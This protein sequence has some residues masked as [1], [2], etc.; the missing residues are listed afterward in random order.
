MWKQN[1]PMSNLHRL[2][3]LSTYFLVIISS[4]TI[5]QQII[6]E[7]DFSD[8]N[9]TENAAWTDPS[10]RYII[11]TTNELQL[12]A[13]AESDTAVIFT[14]STAAFGEWEFLVRYD[15]NPS[16]TSFARIYL[17]ADTSRM[18][19]AV[20]GYYVR[21]GHTDDEVSLYRQDGT[22]DVKII[23][24][25][26]DLID[27]GSVNVRI[28]VTRSTDGS[29]ELLAD[30]AGGQ[31]YT[32]Q[33]TTQD[34]THTISRFFGIF[35][36]YIGSRSTLYF[37]DDVTVI[38]QTPPLVVESVLPIDNNNIEVLFNIPLN[39]NTVEVSD[40]LVNNGIGIP[41]QISIN[42]ERMVS[43]Q[44]E[45]AIPGGSY[46]LA[47]KSQDIEDSAGNSLSQDTIIPFTL[48]D[49]FEPGDIVINEFMYDPPSGLPEYIELIN[50]SSK[51]LN[52]QNWKLEDENIGNDIITTDSLVMDPNSFLVI[53][54]DTAAISTVF[55]SGNY[56]QMSNL[57]SLN[58][59]GDQIQVITLDG[60][61]ADSL[62][63]S[64]AWG[65]TDVALERRD[66]DAPST[67]IENWGDSPASEGGTPGSPN[68]LASDNTPPSLT[69]LGFPDGETLI[70]A[71]SETLDLETS[72]MP[73]NYVLSGEPEIQFI[74]QPAPD[75]VLLSLAPP[76][77]DNT[78]YTLS[79]TNI[80][81]LF[82]NTIIPI[83]TTF[84]FFEISEADPGDVAITEFMY[85]PP[86]G[87]SEFV[88]L[89]NIS[90][91]TIDLKGWRF[92]DGAG[93]REL[94]TEASSVFAPGEFIVLATDKTLLELFPE[95]DLLTMGGNFS[96]L[97]NG[98]DQIKIFKPDDV[99]M[100]S[101]LYDDA[102]GG[103]EVSLE[104]RSTQV[105]SVFQAN[106][107]D[108]PSAEGATPG[109]PNEIET[110]KQPPGIS[111]LTVVDARNIKI[112]FSEQ[113]FNVKN[114]L[115]YTFDPPIDIQNVLVSEDTVNI[116]LAADLISGTTIS[117]SINGVTD[118]FGNQ[119]DEPL[120]QSFTF[121][122]T[123]QPTP[124]A[125]F[126]DEFMY[127][128]PDG[129]SEYIEL[130]NTSSLAL[131]L[132]GLK[133]N[134]NNGSPGTI[135]NKQLVLPAGQR[136]VLVPDS[137]LIPIFSDARFQVIGSA[138]QN[139]NNGGDAI[140]ITDREGN[141]LDSLIY[142]TN[143]G[144][145]GVALERRTTNV[146]AIF[147]ENWGDSPSP[148]FGTPGSVNLVPADE[149]P[150]QLLS[151]EALTESRLR[152]T[153]S[154]R[155]G[156]NSGTDPN[157]YQLSPD[158]PLQMI[159][160]DGSTVELILSQPLV[161]DQE[162]TLIVQNL[163]DL[164]GNTLASSSQ[165]FELFRFQQ[166]RPGDVIINEILYQKA[167]NSD[168]EFV[169]L[170]NRSNRDIDLNLWQ[171]G[172][173]GGNPSFIDAPG[174]VSVIPIPANEFLVLTNDESF[175]STSSDII[176]VRG[177][178]SLNDDED[179][180]F[181]RDGQGK[182]ID[183]L[184]YSS[185][186]GGSE[187]G[188]SL[189]RIDPF[190]A[191]ND[192]SNWRTSQS[193]SGSTP[194]RE[195]S[196]LQID[197]IPPKPNFAT[198]G[199]NGQILITFDEFI[200]QINN[201]TVQ[202]DGNPVDIISF[203]RAD[204]DRILVEGV[205]VDTAAN[206]QIEIR[207]LRDF[208]GNT[209]D[210]A[211]IPLSLPAAPGDV[212]FNEIMYDPITPDRVEK[213]S[214]SEY[215]ELINRSSHAISLEGITIFEQHLADGSLDGRLDIVKTQGKFVPAGGQFLVYSDP[216]ERFK[217]SRIHRFFGLDTIPFFVRVDASSLQLTNTGQPV[218][219]ADSNGVTIDSLVYSPE[220]HNP[221]LFDTKGISLER[222]V[223]AAASNDARNWGSA[224]TNA[225][226]EGGTPGFQ[227]TLFA[228]AEDLEQEN[229]ITLQPNPFS[230]N[231]DGKDDNL[232]IDYNLSETDFLLKVRVF[233]RYGREIRTLADGEP[234]GRSG[235][236]IWDGLDDSG[237]KNRIGYYIIHFEAFNSANGTN[238]VFQK[239]VV[240]ARQ[241]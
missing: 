18:K 166:P 105:S 100:D 9:F 154:E 60:V 31:D 233:D 205:P 97:N 202:I 229:S 34:N 99:L 83:D 152:I 112:L 88:E 109:S 241:L 59:G 213:P 223:P 53:S 51:I 58:N 187:N 75:T 174:Q 221:N 84:M 22:E 48:F 145:E 235:T 8:G 116:L 148:D 110:D 140:I 207:N 4:N 117:L 198:L 141:T 199:E 132:A 16:S 65:G 27:T 5:A 239:T 181:I 178:P 225:I 144:G 70:L 175:A 118:L 82:G 91:K 209:T 44:F 165:M 127:D 52:L 50:T 186:W 96:S 150:P 36:K 193:D 220:W 149:T 183:S 164:F 215:V 238:Q 203:N 128:P 111:S 92:N 12:N 119:P 211:R 142:T 10:N 147:R 126:I 201:M 46:E 26:D 87:L 3:L 204:A 77:V 218:I 76:M 236:I 43:L 151:V 89:Q 67:A 216:A 135:S 138:F 62:A 121:F 200:Q 184:F 153:L 196:I 104:R 86:D 214:Q 185:T 179:A 192:R 107:G 163:Q 232:V 226:P 146:A 172:D 160:V 169:E 182:T 162:F 39:Q 191:S 79:A 123:E 61:L 55:G 217:D 222:K 37:Y 139:L 143:W 206:P 93:G 130:R 24:G 6:I 80:E 7:D 1:G 15:F 134:D 170:F 63:Y 133:I 129:Y 137:T 32:S 28:Q 195:N 64:P 131:D 176:A 173:S 231:E 212:V 20:D 240:L 45:E 35:S 98:G 49:F 101:L 156:E 69:G 157:T 14:Q 210:V 113:V 158:R 167:A 40:F 71:F 120:T 159:L 136:M 21:V 171:L 78:S 177:F 73:N 188:F 103:Q 234:A 180:V 197:D 25:T 85:D 108:S 57:S 11:N 194:G 94:I 95:I 155:P 189:E 33:G 115:Q 124:N 190:R 106:W 228:P 230:P 72:Q 54:S 66:V 41:Q 208:R 81:D 47:I 68:L 219:L 227:N 30:P 168:V 74:T 17:V 224:S 23:D 114:P 42:N 237:R 161:T 19:S 125:L 90:N 122:E 13:P 102:W 29:W 2:F 56:Q 38:K